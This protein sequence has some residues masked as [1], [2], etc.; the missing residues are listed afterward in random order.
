MVAIT[1]D[2]IEEYLACGQE[3]FLLPLKDYAVS[4][5]KTYTKKEIKDLREK[6][7]SLE[8]FVVINKTIFNK[9]LKEL[10]QV[11]DYLENLSIQGIFFYDLAILEIKQRKNLKTPLVWNQTHMVTNSKTCNF[12]YENGVE[13]AKIAGELEKSEILNLIKNTKIKLC[14]TLL[15]KPVVAHSRRSLITNYKRIVEKKPKEKL[16]I[17]EKL[18]D[19]DYLVT[20][21]KDGTSFLYSKIPNH[22]TIL[23]DLEVDY[24]IL[25]E[26][27]IEHSVFI[28]ILDA[29]NQYLNK[30][31]LFDLLLEKV[32]PYLENPP[33][34]NNKTI[35][36]VKKEGK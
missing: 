4:Y 36:R 28:K 25:N 30:K 26:S 14:Y 15:S 23:K 21:S 9:D 17:H 2:N 35:Y 12:Y 34:L 32:S 8:L 22:Y 31:I 1:T 20:E 18:E 11:L 27:Y 19:Q 3:C 24:L 5:E 6:Y 16:I 13:Y 7:P 33:F 29:T 10:E